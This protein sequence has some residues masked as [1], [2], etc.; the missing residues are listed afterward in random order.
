[1]STKA[2]CQYHRP[3]YPRPQ[4]H[5]PLQS[6][7]LRFEAGD[8]TPK[9]LV[10]RVRQPSWPT[11][12]YESHEFLYFFLQVGVISLQRGVISL[13]RGVIS[14]QR[15]VISLQRRQRGSHCGQLH[16]SRIRFAWGVQSHKRQF[17]M[18]LFIPTRGMHFPSLR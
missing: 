2:Q 17:E 5:R 6:Q 1:V 9:N 16:K 4:Y 15:G 13:Q 8:E 12:R 10:Q 14:L 7:H 3:Q 11:L 18:G